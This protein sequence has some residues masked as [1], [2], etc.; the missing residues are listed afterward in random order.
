MAVSVTGL[1][2]RASRLVSPKGEMIGIVLTPKD[3]EALVEFLEDLDVLQEI[4]AKGEEE[5]AIPWE[6]A[7]KILND[8][9]VDV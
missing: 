6:D 4:E 9:S 5:Q 3:W 2:E 8:K 7:L 1:L